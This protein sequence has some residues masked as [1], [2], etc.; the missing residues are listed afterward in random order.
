MIQHFPEVF[1]E[2]LV[3]VA[4]PSDIKI[5]TECSASFQSYATSS[6]SSSTYGGRKI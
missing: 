6:T 5:D 4:T 2:F 3:N 1:Q